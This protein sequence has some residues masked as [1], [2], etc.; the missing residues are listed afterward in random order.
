L[1]NNGKRLTTHNPGSGGLG[2]LTV[3]KENLLGILKS[4]AHAFLAHHK[5]A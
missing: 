1:L 2:L 3:S 5:T 4:E